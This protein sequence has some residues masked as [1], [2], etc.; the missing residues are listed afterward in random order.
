VLGTVEP[1]EV[2]ATVTVNGTIAVVLGIITMGERSAS[3]EIL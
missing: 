3:P 1:G 2:D